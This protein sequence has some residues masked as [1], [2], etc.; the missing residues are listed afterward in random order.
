MARAL[1][2]ATEKRGL[3]VEIVRTGSRGMYWLEPTIEVERP[4]GRVGYGPAKAS[5]V[6]SLLDAGTFEGGKHPLSLGLVQDIPFFKRQTHLP[7]PASASSIPSTRTISKPTGA[8]RGYAGPS[9]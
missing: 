7:S 6:D 2:K 5:D 9:P 3:D 1:F 8:W 4:E